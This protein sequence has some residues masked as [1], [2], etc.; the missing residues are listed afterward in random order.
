MR[1]VNSR[2]MRAKM[3]LEIATALYTE[4][5]FDLGNVTTISINSGSDE[6]QF[7]PLRIGINGDLNGG[8]RAPIEVGKK[9]VDVACVNPSAVV[10]MAYRGK[11][12][13]KEKMPIRALAALP[14][15]DRIAFAVSK[16]LNLKSLTEIRER[17]IPL[18]ISTRSSGVDNTTYYTLSK[19]FSFY[20][21]SFNRIKSWGGDIEEIAWPSSTI[22]K[23]SIRRRKVDAIFD[24]GINSWLPEALDNGYEVL[25]MERSVIKEMEKLGF[26]E[27][28]IPRSRFRKLKE[29]I[30]TLDFSGWPLITHRWLSDDMAYSICESIDARQKSIPVDDP[31]PLNMRTICKDTENG[32]LAIPFHPGARKYYEKNGYL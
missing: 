27:A 6:P 14:S 8:M 18:R 28:T 7:A 1:R 17:R 22:R 11:G 30:R 20:G 4:R 16:E 9:R 29:D 13:F 15:W 3:A 19:I 12:F 23:D 32:P 2:M 5:M 31:G 25:H 21:L 26:R 10:T 24:E